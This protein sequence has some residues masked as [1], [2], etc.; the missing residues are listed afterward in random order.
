ML[1]GLGE[2][3]LERYCIDLGWAGFRRRLAA[4]A[5]LVGIAIYMLIDH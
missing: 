3:V 2:G 1:E 5:L 4:S